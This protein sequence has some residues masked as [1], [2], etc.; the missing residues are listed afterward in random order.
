MRTKCYLEHKE[1]LLKNSIKIGVTGGI[2]SGKSLVCKLFEIYS[3]PCYYA[4]TEAKQLMINDQNLVGQIKSLL[5]DSAYLADGNLNRDYI[6]KKVFNDRS[7]LEALNK[8]VHPAVKQDFEWWTL[9]Q[10]SPIVL[11]ESAILIEEGIY[12]HFDKIILVKATL[13]KK[14]ARIKKR[15]NWSEEAILE[16][17]NNQWSDEKKEPFADFIIDN[18]ENKSLILQI[19]AIYNK[20]KN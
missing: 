14:I 1:T 3:I 9:N 18:S 12:K 6:S 17:M 20:L 5:G 16:R 4:D 2:G 8:L 13:D 7:L 19:D 11:E 15:N 10:T